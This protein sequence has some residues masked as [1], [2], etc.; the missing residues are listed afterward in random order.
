MNLVDLL[1]KSGLHYCAMAGANKYGE[2]PLSNEIPFDA[3]AGR[4]VWFGPISV[5]LK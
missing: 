5:S 3:G 1:P 4:T 2:G